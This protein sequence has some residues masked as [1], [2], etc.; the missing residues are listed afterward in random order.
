[1]L[2]AVGRSPNSERVVKVA[3]QLAVA[4]GAR[5]RVVHFREV[6]AGRMGPSWSEP[7]ADARE[8]TK[9]AMAQVRE[10]GVAQ[11]SGCVRPVHARFVAEAIAA[12]AADWGA[13]LIVTG[14]RWRNRVAS[15]LFGGTSNAIM[16]LGP[17][18][19][20]VVTPRSRVASDTKAR[21]D[22]SG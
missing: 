10:C 2:V 9:R 15:L 13:H 22:Q 5:V 3:A 16:R 20:V 18:P 17:C 8:L 12:E 1:V 11:V 21:A 19:V 4:I 6:E 7:A 14:A